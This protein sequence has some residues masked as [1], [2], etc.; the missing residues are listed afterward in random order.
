MVVVAR[1][2]LEDNFT[3]AGAGTGLVDIV[4]GGTPGFLCCVVWEYEDGADSGGGGLEA[5][6][7]SVNP[8]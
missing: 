5:V 3:D 8:R 6:P 7:A 2:Q 4:I 1:P